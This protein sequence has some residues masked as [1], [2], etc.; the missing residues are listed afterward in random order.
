[1]AQGDTTMSVRYDIGQ[2]LR[3]G[4]ALARI[5]VDELGRRMHDAGYQL[6]GRTLASI[7][8]GYRRASW[9]EVEQLAEV[10]GVTPGFLTADV[11]TIAAVPDHADIERVLSE[12]AEGHDAP[13]ELAIEALSRWRRWRDI[14]VEPRQALAG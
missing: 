3:A 8:R 9:E 1:M 2:A 11:A 12:I 10:L 13:R 7:E 6:G 4:R 14:N 5:S